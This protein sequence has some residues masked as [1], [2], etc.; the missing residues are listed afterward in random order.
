MRQFASA[1]F[2]ALVVVGSLLPVTAPANASNSDESSH[3]MAQI[4]E[5]FGLPPF[6][7]GIP[8]QNHYGVTL[9]ATEL[10]YLERVDEVIERSKSLA[11][12]L[13]RVPNQFGGL[14]FDRA[15]GALRV[16][17]VRP[18][19]ATVALVAGHEPGTPVIREDVRYALAELSEVQ[20]QI[21]TSFDASQFAMIA[22]DIPNNR[23]VANLLPTSD[24][25]LGTKLTA[26]FGD[27]VTVGVT[28]AIATMACGTRYN[29][30][31]PL[32]GG[33]EIRRTSDNVPC[34]TGFVYQSA[35]YLGTSKGKV[36]TTAGHCGW[37]NGSW[38]TA[39]F[40]IGTVYQNTNVTG[41]NADVMFIDISDSHGSNDV[42]Q[43]YDGSSGTG[44]IIDITSRGCANEISG[45]SCE[46]VGQTVCY[47]GR[48]T[49][50][51]C[52]TLALINIT[53]SDTSGVTKHHQRAVNTNTSKG[54]DSG[55][56]VYASAKAWGHLWGGDSNYWVY[57]HRHY[58]ADY[59]SHI[60]TCNVQIV[61]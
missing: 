54:G 26:A 28:E 39:G 42:Y 11:V 13:D 27:R 23:V 41:T 31:P 17:L 1:A 30:A 47:S 2:V 7:T 60:T 21:E 5:N 32:R 29:C 58:V 15:N 45:S 8:V 16:Q 49:G 43:S 9:N 53:V 6:P 24:P 59:C 44:N 52:S 55:A 56:A 19:A 20:G 57:S 35:S 18:T 22:V 12:E 46:A 10:A 4:R 3:L 14:W 37:V 34:T 50:Q 61:N 51:K 38:K 40:T 48:T 33:L 36:A 25:A